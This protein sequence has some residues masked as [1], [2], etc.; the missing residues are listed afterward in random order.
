MKAIYNSRIV[1]QENIQISVANRGFCYGDGLFETI[2][3]GPDRINLVNHHVQRLKRH[4]AVLLLNLTDKFCIELKDQIEELRVANQLHEGCRTKVMVWR[5]EGGL[6]ASTEHDF[7]Y[8]ITQKAT[9]KTLVNASGIIGVAKTIRNHHSIHSHL[10]SLNALDYV[11]AGNEMLERSLD[12]IILLDANNH[13]S[14]THIGN[15]FWLKGQQ[16]FTPPLTTGC[17]EGVM[18]NFLIDFFQDKVRAVKEKLATEEEL[19]QADSIFSSNAS[20]ITYY[21]N[22]EGSKKALQH[23]KPHLAAFIKR[24]QQP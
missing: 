4:A 21:S 18:R 15:L 8:L 10:K 23:P 2:V 1:D 24:L 13:L 20:G 16:L 7:E 14:E 5:S 17:V 12:E 11:L 19:K 3:T 6:Y 9:Q 22:L